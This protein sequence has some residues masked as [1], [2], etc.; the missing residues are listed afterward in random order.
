MYLVSGETF[1][2]GVDVGQGLGGILEGRKG[3]ET[4]DAV[5]GGH[6]EDGGFDLGLEGRNFFEFFDAEEAVA[7]RVLKEHHRHGHGWLTVITF[8][9]Y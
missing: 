8:L 5:E 6:V 2:D 4:D 9:R 7:G 1:G 3:E